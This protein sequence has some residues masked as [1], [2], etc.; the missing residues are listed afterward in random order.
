MG[1]RIRPFSY[2]GLITRRASGSQPASNG[3]RTRSE[4]GHSKPGSNPARFNRQFDR[5]RS[6]GRSLRGDEF[7]AA[8]I[9]R[10]ILNSTVT[11]RSPERV[12]GA[13]ANSLKSAEWSPN[14]LVVSRVALPAY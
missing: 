13:L 5:E 14:A 7:P 11:D 12:A 1:D 9:G 2:A 3:T 8:E 10:L 6:T 4:A